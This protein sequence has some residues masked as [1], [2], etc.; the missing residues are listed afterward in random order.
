V[1][2]NTVYDTYG[3]G[4]N[5]SN[6]NYG[7]VYNNTLYG[8]MKWPLVSATNSDS[9]VQGMRIYNNTLYN[10]GKDFLWG[11]GNHPNWLY[12]FSEGI[13]C[14][15][16]GAEAYYKDLYI[17]NNK[18]YNDYDP[19]QVWP[20]AFMHIGMGNS[21]GYGDWNGLYIYNNVMFNGNCY[22]TNGIEFQ[23][24]MGG[25]FSNVHIYNNSL[26]KSSAVD[27]SLIHLMFYAAAKNTTNLYIKNNILYSSYATTES[28]MNIPSKAMVTGDYQVNNNLYYGVGTLDFFAG[29]YDNRVKVDHPENYYTFAKWQSDDADGMAFDKNGIGTSTDP[30][31]TSLTPAS[32]NLALQAGSP[33]INKGANLSAY[34]TTD[35]AGATRTGTWD[36][37]AY[38]SGTGG[39][40][41]GLT[42][43]IE[44]GPHTITISPTG[45]TFTSQ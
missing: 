37:G 4:I 29:P 15:T 31:F 21:C 26:W 28:V 38:E 24:G 19:P 12:V 17:Y 6:S 11:P 35:Y 32:F 9:G 39:G 40:A 7:E 3:D 42:F 10:V 36:I 13:T 20:A 34:F 45:K 43:T 14:P 1:Y 25:S 16:T 41:T 18:F 33:A 8:K 44:A 2:N 30:L 23:T 27:G 22:S 5:L